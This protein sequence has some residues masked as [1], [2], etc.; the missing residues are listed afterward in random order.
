MDSDKSDAGSKADGFS[1]QMTTF[2]VFYH[3]SLLCRVFGYMDGIN[4]VLQSQSLYFLQATS[5]ILCAGSGGGGDFEHP[6]Y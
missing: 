1:K 5:M 2:D 4:S 3:P 6:H